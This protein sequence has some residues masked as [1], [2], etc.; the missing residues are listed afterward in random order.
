MS[1]TPIRLVPMIIIMT[2]TFYVLCLVITAA[3]TDLIKLRIPNIMPVL[4]TASFVLAIAIDVF[5][6]AGI[7]QSPTSHLIAGA[8]VFAVMLILFFM[9]LFGGGDAKLIPAVALWVGLQG[10][11]VFLMMTTIIGGI[12]ALLSIFLRKTKIGQTLLTKLLHYPKLTD[13]WFG[14]MA[15]GETVIPYG[16]AIAIGTFAAF[17]DVGLLP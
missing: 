12:L 14:A 1:V 11:P 2:L 3:Y 17:R 10:L 13:G 4:I 6:G 16:L 7:F 8:I 9:R 5:T 15:K